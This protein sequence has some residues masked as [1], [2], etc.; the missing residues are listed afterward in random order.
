MSSPRRGEVKV[1]LRKLIS[2]KTILLKRPA[3]NRRLSIGDAACMVQP[4]VDD[5]PL[6]APAGPEV[7]KRR[8]S[9][10]KF[11]E[12]FQRIAGGRHCRIH[13]LSLQPTIPLRQHLGFPL[14]L[15]HRRRVLVTKVEAPSE[16]RP[17]VVA[18]VFGC[19]SCA[20]SLGG[21]IRKTPGSAVPMNIFKTHYAWEGLNVSKC[22]HLLVKQLR[23]MSQSCAST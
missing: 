14:I 19:R 21:A 13:W 12:E 9:V 20:A 15:S 6:V 17:R 8:S 7:Q 5:L 11:A 23:P 22:V 2:S 4:G 3:L 16:K 1:S 10:L 18:L